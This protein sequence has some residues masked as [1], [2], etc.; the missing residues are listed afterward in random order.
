MN[1]LKSLC[2]NWNKRLKSESKSCKLMTASWCLCQHLH[3]I[4]N[5]KHQSSQKVHH[6]CFCS[7]NDKS[8]AKATSFL[9]RHFCYVIFAISFLQCNFDSQ[10]YSHFPFRSKPLRR[11]HSCPCRQQWSSIVLIKFIKYAQIL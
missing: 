5:R 10:N 11:P 4:W 7:K 3:V 6:M 1:M 2:L 9:P 8:V